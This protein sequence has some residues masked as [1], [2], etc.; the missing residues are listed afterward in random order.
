MQNY[1]QV[2]PSGIKYNRQIY[3]THQLTLI[4]T[5]LMFRSCF[6]LSIWLS[7]CFELHV[8][9]VYVF[10]IDLSTEHLT[11][12]TSVMCLESQLVCNC[13]QSVQS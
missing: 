4:K 9:P 3:D 2:W 11:C 7:T 8:E 1:T 6:V 5:Y 10:L 12:S 13:P